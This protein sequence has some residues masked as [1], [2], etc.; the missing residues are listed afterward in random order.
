MTRIGWTAL[1]VAILISAYSIAEAIAV[2]I[3]GHPMLD[4]DAGPKVANGAVGLLLALTFAL[5]VA[6]LREQSARIDAGSRPRRWLRRLLQADLAVCAVVGAVTVVLTLTR[7]SEAIEATLGAI[8][9]S[10]FILAFVLGAALGISLIS[11]ADLRAGSVCLSAIAVLV[12]L[13]ILM[14][15][16]QSPWGHIAY[17]ETALYIGIALLARKPQPVGLAR[18]TRRRSA[19]RLA[20]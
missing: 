2:G 4:P 7:R 13:T 9:G 1:G 10:G 17:A 5:S 15:V 16:L 11:R 18:P 6:V 20:V 8:G 19:A 3:S 14:G 12:P